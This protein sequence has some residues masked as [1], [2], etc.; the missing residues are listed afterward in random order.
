M[1]FEEISFRERKEI[2]DYY[3]LNNL[4]SPINVT[5]F[6]KLRL[7]FRYHVFKGIKPGSKKW[8]VVQEK[9]ANLPN[10]DYYAYKRNLFYMA[11]LNCGNSFYTHPMLCILYP[12]NL[13]IGENVFFNRNVYIT[14]F[15]KVCIGNNV[16]IGPN[17]IINSGNHNY[18]NSKVL[19]AEQGHTYKPI[20][21][22]ND[23]WIGAD[24]KILAGVTIGKGA[25]VGA[26][27]VVTKNIAPYSVVAGI[28]ARAIKKRI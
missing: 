21:I 7:C 25:V 20:I 8:H 26:G 2:Q 22:E 11:T 16:L 19:I 9:I 28:P 27:S 10:V 12:N 18:L 24:C 6:N 13:E 3:M 5:L 14:A 23:V 4:G 17:T 15:E 1:K